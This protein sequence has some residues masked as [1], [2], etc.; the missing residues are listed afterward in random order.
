MKNCSSCHCVA[1]CS[2]ECK[3]EDE[4]LHKTVCPLLD[5]C[6]QDYRFQITNGDKL[7][8][9]LPPKMA[10]LKLP[11]QDFE[12]MFVE[13]CEGL[14]SPSDSKEYK[15]SQV[16]KILVLS[17]HFVMSTTFRCAN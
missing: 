10:K 14:F 9:Y 2:D 8:C 15:K 17:K 4:A 3:K 7:K 12:K 13:E 16:E 11:E 1:Y 6:I 5:N